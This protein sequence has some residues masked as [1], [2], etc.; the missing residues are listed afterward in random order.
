MAI[1]TLGAVSPSQVPTL[2]CED[3]EHEPLLALRRDAYLAEG[4]RSLCAVP[5]H[6]YGENSG[7]IVFYF[8]NTHRFGQGEI[9]VATALANLAS[10]AMTTAELFQEQTRLRLA[11]EDAN[12]LKDE[13]LATVSH[14]LRTPLTPLLG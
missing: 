9:R 4:I 8:H 3:I 1:E 11:A 6:L 5:L 10:A 7:T 14:E 2:I 12:R 13:F